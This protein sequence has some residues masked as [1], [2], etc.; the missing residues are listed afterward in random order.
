MNEKGYSDDVAAAYLVFQRM[1]MKNRKM[2]VKYYEEFINKYTDISDFSFIEKESLLAPFMGDNLEKVV[3]MYPEIN[4]Q[5]LSEDK[6]VELLVGFLGA[7]EKEN[8][9]EL[10]EKFKHLKKE[11]IKWR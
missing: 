6:L 9:E 1:S 4:Y 7:L 2:L 10:K 11:R 5:T 3:P 8:K